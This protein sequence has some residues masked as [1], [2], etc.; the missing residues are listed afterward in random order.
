MPHGCILLRRLSSCAIDRVASLLHWSIERVCCSGRTSHTP[1]NPCEQRFI[2]FET[3]SGRF[4]VVWKKMHLLRRKRPRTKTFN[5][6]Q[7]CQVSCLYWCLYTALKRGF[8][9]GRLSSCTSYFTRENTSKARFL[10]IHSR[11]T[12]RSKTG[13]EWVALWDLQAMLL[14]CSKLQYMQHFLYFRL[15]FLWAF[16]IAFSPQQTSQQTFYRKPA[17]C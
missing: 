16:Y 4:F 6:W 12:Y 3:K 14:S 8:N 7:T 13:E 2:S 9:W 1:I 17:W 5:L 10:S 15:A 11:S